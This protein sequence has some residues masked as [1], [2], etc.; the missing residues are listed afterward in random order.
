MDTYTQ[1]QEITIVF[2]IK[3][4]PYEINATFLGTGRT[5]GGV[6]FGH[7]QRSDKPNQKPYLLS[8]KAIANMQ[9]ADWANVK[10]TW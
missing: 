7:F 6:E 9:G 1:G 5:I 3:D 4:T 2:V 8:K 10:T